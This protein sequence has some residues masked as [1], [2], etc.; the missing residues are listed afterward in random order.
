MSKFLKLVEMHEPGVDSEG[1]DPLQDLF[2]KEHV[3]H[4]EYDK[5][6]GTIKANLTHGGVLELQYIRIQ[7]P[8]EEE[9]EQLASTMLGT[10]I[11]APKPKM[12]S[13][14]SAARKFYSAK[15][16]LAA[17]ASKWVDQLSSY[18]SKSNLKI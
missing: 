10:I 9:N 4:V 14:D 1:Y 18:L 7:R 17:T 5:N 6:S 15:D 12:F 3:S 8:K 13:M 11:N 2:N 16:K